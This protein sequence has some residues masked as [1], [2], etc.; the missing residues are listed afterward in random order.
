[1]QDDRNRL[2]GRLRRAARRIA[3]REDHV[4]PRARV[5]AASAGSRSSLAFGSRMSMSTFW[6]SMK[7][8]S[9]ARATDASRIPHRLEYTAR[10][11]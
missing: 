4:A 10:P 3:K 9:R 1:M 5:A 8:S 11:D 7:P 6:P 2:G